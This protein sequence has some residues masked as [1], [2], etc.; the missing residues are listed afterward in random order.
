MKEVLDRILQIENGFRHI[1][2]GANEIISKYPKEKSL[3]TALEYY[4]NEAYQ[5]RMLATVILG[6]LAVESPE[7]YCFLKEKVS[8]DKN[9]R[10]QEM[11]ATA[12]DLICKEK[13]Y[14]NS[15]PLI[16]EWTND[17]NPNLVRA[18]TEGLRFWTN[19]PFFKDNP[20]LAITLISKHKSHQSE[21]VRKSV[22]NAL[23]D[24]SRKYESL[25]KDELKSWDLSNP[26]IQFTYK[27][28]TKHLKRNDK[29]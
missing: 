28:A 11:L 27:Y 29:L 22:G 26:L 23:K 10:V 9:W 8:I 4:K 21:F 16:E 17:E 24:I 20:S 6:N 14:E 7:A 18:V 12:F 5:A 3:K 1:Y 19:R 25:L 15:I 13:G 2:D